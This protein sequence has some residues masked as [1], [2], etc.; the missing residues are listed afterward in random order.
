MLLAAYLA[1]RGQLPMDAPAASSFAAIR[2]F[3]FGEEYT[4]ELTLDGQ[5]SSY[6]FDTLA[7][8]L[9]V[10]TS[11]FEADERF[12]PNIEI[13]TYKATRDPKFGVTTLA[14]GERKGFTPNPMQERQ[15]QIIQTFTGINKPIPTFGPAIDR[16]LAVTH[17]ERN[18]AFPRPPIAF[19][20]EDIEKAVTYYSLTGTWDQMDGRSNL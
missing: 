2:A 19:Y 14:R 4:V 13:A 8:A 5:V 9:A 7:D 11:E 6:R 3:L 1:S 18:M 17:A 10:L 15:A 16:V 20:T 12:I